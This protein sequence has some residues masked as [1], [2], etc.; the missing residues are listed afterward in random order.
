MA[1][2]WRSTSSP[3]APSGWADTIPTLRCSGVSC[4]QGRREC[5]TPQACQLAESDHEAIR[6]MSLHSRFERG[7]LLAL[8]LAAL[9]VVA[10]AFF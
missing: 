6:F 9:A 5:T 4:R 8:A 2:Q 7:V 10:L 3:D 1:R